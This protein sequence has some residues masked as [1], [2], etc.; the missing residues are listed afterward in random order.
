MGEM[1]STLAHELNQPLAAISSY[2]AGCLNQLERENA[3]PSE[4][5]DILAKLGKQAQRAGQ[6]IKRVHNFVRRSEPK[7]EMVDIN[8][9]IREAVALVE[10]D[11]RKRLARI[12]TALAPRLAEVPADPI[13]IEQVVV[14]LLRNG[15][16]AMVD[17]PPAHRVLHIATRT[18]DGQVLIQVADRGRGIP[19][20]AAARL[21]QPFYTTKA[22][23]M[24]MGLNICRSIAELHRGKL[25]FEPNPGGGTIFTFALPIEPL[26]PRPPS[27]PPWPISSMTTRPSATPWNG[28]SRA[29]ASPAHADLRR[30]IFWAPG[31]P[32]GA[33]AWCWTSAWRG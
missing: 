27:P 11:A 32:P 4:L 7:R 20:E 5:K 15:M 30:R 18:R 29:A 22:E 2:S 23:G 33:A 13:M 8:A 16:D 17:I 28:C 3:D 1:A 9:L 25:G 12:E 19:P 24:G 31:A 21:F 26:C 6:I 14:N 10:P